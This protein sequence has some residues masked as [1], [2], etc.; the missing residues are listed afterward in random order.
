MENKR[1]AGVLLHISSLP[2]A[3]G[4]GTLGKEA[5]KFVDFLAESKMSYWQILPLN[6][7]SYGDSP[8]Q[9]PSSTGLNYYF[10]DLDTLV[11]KG[12]LKEEEIDDSK[13]YID[14]TR[15]NYG[16][17][18]NSRISILEKAFSR[19]D[20]Q[21]RDFLKFEEEGKY[22]DFAFYMTLK[23]L[24]DYRPHYQWSEHYRHY[25]K[26]LE[27]EI[28]LTHHDIYLFYV[29]T[30]YEFLLEYNKLISYAHTK[31][32]SIIG[33][34]PLYLAYDSLEFYKYP[35]LFLVDNDYK[36]TLVAGC[37]PDYF[38]PKG[39]LWGNPI[40]DWQSMEKDN[41]SWFRK[42]LMNNF[43]HFDVLRI[44]HFRGLA[45]YYTIKY[46]AQDA[47]IGKWVKGPGSK[48]FD[49]LLDLPIIAEDLGF[50]DD[51]ARKLLKE[52]KYPGMKVLEFAF[53]GDATNEHKPS[54]CQ[55]NYFC[56]TGT[57]DNMPLVGY[58]SSLSKEGLETL[59]KDVE[60]ECKKL[61][62]EFKGDN[63][64][65]LAFSI[66]ILALNT[67]CRTAI[68]P[69]QDILLSG[70]E[71]R[72]NTPSILSDKNWVYRIKK[73]DLNSELSSKL[74]NIVVN[75]KRG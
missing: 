45:A 11:D 22:R 68:L 10:I 57:H 63:I 31:G 69:M 1:K 20:K 50:I 34:M 21:D 49:G 6:V 66:T 32:I 29:W 71:T 44:D 61:N 51:E 70:N 35:D 54:N 75:S 40:Y 41:Y 65:E 42:R 47:V 64:K 8:Y 24:N 28:I 30:Q 39:Q 15:V 5:Y 36:P 56:Y 37:P 72:M 43:E 19:F 3:H 27:E 73:E 67:A 7:T 23:I 16:M 4:I 14:E 74:A 53:D 12:L 38:A 60:S 18:F 26:E 46:G 25:S 52:T 2:S 58:I 13:L 33:D 17:L 48:L 55:E 62:V 9:S 59:A